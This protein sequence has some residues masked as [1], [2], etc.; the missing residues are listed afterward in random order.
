MNTVF[1]Q[2]IQTSTDTDRQLRAVTKN[3][4]QLWQKHYSFEALKGARYGESFCDYFNIRDYRLY[5]DNVPERCDQLIRK[6][7]IV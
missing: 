6:D 3:Q 5:Y 7:W 1:Q 4:Y 2:L